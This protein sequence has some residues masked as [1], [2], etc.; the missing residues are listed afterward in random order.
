M[1]ELDE[2]VNEI[3]DQLNQ[4]VPYDSASVQILD[5][6]ELEIIGGR[7][8]ENLENVIG[9]RFHIPGN[10]PNSVVIETRKPYHL[11]K[12][13]RYMKRSTTLRIIISAHG[14]G[15]RLSYRKR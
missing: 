14:W 2:T 4:V 5:G 11:P 8:W 13:G 6:N 12:H 1:L 9:I 10:N 7:G 15:C 3:L